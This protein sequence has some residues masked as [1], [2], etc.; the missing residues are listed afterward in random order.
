MK[1]VVSECSE[2]RIKMVRGVGLGRVMKQARASVSPVGS[3]PA[4]GQA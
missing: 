4:I 1:E 2:A 3:P